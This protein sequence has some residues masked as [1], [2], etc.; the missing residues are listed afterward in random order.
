M[1]CQLGLARFGVAE[2][3]LLLRA[4]GV[5][6][7]PDAP[8]AWVSACA[9]ETPLEDTNIVMDISL[10]LVLLSTSVPR[11]YLPQSR[12]CIVCRDVPISPRPAD[13]VCSSARAP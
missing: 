4:D 2:R 9:C 13:S 7:T 3:L 8:T 5:Q 6:D 10:L 1:V 12:S 11:C